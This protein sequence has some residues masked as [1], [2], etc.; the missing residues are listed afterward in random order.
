[1]ALFVFQ[2]DGDPN[3]LYLIGISES[4]AAHRAY[5]ESPESHEQF[6]AMRA[7][8]EAEPEWHDGRV[9]RYKTK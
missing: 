6:L 7:W 1:V 2:M 3:E 5:S 4:E 8:L 9:L